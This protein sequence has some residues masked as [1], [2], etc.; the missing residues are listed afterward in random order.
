MRISLSLACFIWLALDSFAENRGVAIDPKPM[1]KITED[2][3]APL[4]GEYDRSGYTKP[5][6]VLWLSGPEDHGGGE[7]DYIRT[8]EHFVPMLRTIPGVEVTTAFRFPSK[9][10]FDEADV[11]VMYLHLPDLTEKQYD[12]FDGFVQRGGGVLTIHESCIMR[13]MDRAERLAEVIGCSWDGNAKSHWGKFDQ[14]F[15][16]VLDTSHEVFQGL[17]NRLSLRDESYWN[18]LRQPN[19][20]VVGGISTAEPKI[21]DDSLK[22]LL[23]RGDARPDAFWVYEKGEGRVFGTTLG[24]F[25]Y[26]FHDPKFRLLLVRG[27]GWISRRS[28]Q[29]LMPIVTHGLGPENGKYGL[30]SNE[31]M[32]DYKNRKDPS[33]KNAGNE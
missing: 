2:D 23:D 4:L 20:R 5:L 22:A 7:H 28:P 32:L 17:P 30:G 8:Q 6:R 10:Q 16:V 27:L 12:L 33:A 19:V 18:L 13:P 31:T 14:R 1:P 26:T 25:Y 9:R 11:L 29:P 15:G 24:H 3:L 21:A